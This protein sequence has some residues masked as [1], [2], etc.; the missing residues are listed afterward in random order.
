MFTKHNSRLKFISFALK[1]FLFLLL[2]MFNKAEASPLKVHPANPRYFYDDSGK[3]IYM[4]GS[5]TWYILHEEGHAVNKERITSY[6]DW[7]HS[8]GHNYTRVWTNW[9]YLKNSKGPQKPWPYLRTGPG[10]A[11]DGLPKFDLSKPDPEYFNLL[12][13]FMQELEKRDM[14]CSIMFFGS[15]NQFRD[16]FQSNTAWH[17]DNNI[18][19]ETGILSANTDFFTTNRGLLALQEAHIKRVIDSLNGF[20]N[21]IWE[22]MNEAE[23]PASGDWRVHMMNVIRNYENTK[24]KKHLILM[25]GGYSEAG[26]ILVN[27][28]ADVISPDTYPGNCKSGCPVTYCGKVIIN[29]SDHLWGFSSLSNR[30]T[31]EKWVWQTFTRGN[32]PLFMD[33]YDAYTNNNGTINH[34]WDKLR[35]NLGYTVNYAAKITD[36]AAMEPSTS[37]S[38]T[39]YCLYNEGKEYLVYQPGTGSFTV[40]M[41]KGK[42]QRE[43]FDPDDAS[44][45]IDTMEVT[46]DGKTSFVKP[47]HIASDAVLY[48]REAGQT[49]WNKIFTTLFGCFFNRLIFGHYLI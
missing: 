23:L 3:P 6:L 17:P 15:Y 35:K 8:F 11:N 36:L 7:L 27:S 29:D 47:S 33:D 25:G 16:N 1:S 24:P 32:H 45:S 41:K 18:N 5:H 42:Y 22:I 9:F 26:N 43:W 38:S 30:I 37:I 48:L 19:P 2:L 34:M 20:D 44:V 28:P 21:L 10:N 40:N 12:K 14:Y 49:N 39:Q 4:A 13:F 31:M 46:S